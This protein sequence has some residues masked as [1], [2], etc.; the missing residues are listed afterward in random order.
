VNKG[1]SSK[2]EM[3]NEVAVIAKTVVRMEKN[4]RFWKRLWRSSS[5]IVRLPMDQNLYT[6]HKFNLQIKSQQ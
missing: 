6:N 2:Y 4:A 3:A 5:L 1:W